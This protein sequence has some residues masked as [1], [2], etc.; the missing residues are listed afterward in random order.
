MHTDTFTLAV[1]LAKRGSAGLPPIIKATYAFE[2]IWAVAAALLFLW[3]LCRLTILPI[4]ATP[5]GP[6]VLLAFTSLCAAIAFVLSAVPFEVNMPTDVYLKTMMSSAFICDVSRALGPAVILWLLHIRGQVFGNSKPG[7]TSSNSARIWKRGVDWSFVA[8]TFI[9][10]I[11][12]HAY[13]LAKNLELVYHGINY[14]T[15]L[16]YQ[17]IM[18]RMRHATTAL[19]FL[20]AINITGAVL[21]LRV[22]QKRAKYSDPV[23]TRLLVAAVPFVLLAAVVWLIFDIVHAVA[24]IYNQE[25]NISFVILDGLAQVGTLT[26][27]ASTIGL[28][29]QTQTHLSDSS[30]NLVRPSSAPNQ[31]I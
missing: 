29:K 2:V 12:F 23:V 4:K 17:K 28:H 24:R 26:A 25:G 11:S 22:T 5:R 8:I 21:L 10:L 1:G 30:S 18:T 3:I 14:E 27:I 15:Y 19:I 20:L 6:Y 9:A 7:Y 31:E 13:N 16:E